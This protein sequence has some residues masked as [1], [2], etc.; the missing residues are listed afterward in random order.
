M[1]TLPYHLI[2]YESSIIGAQFGGIGFSD[3]SPKLLVIATPAGQD[4][5]GFSGPRTNATFSCAPLIYKF[6]CFAKKMYYASSV[7]PPF[8]VLA[9]IMKVF[10]TTWLPDEVLYGEI[11]SQKG[12]NGVLYVTGYGGT[13]A[14]MGK[15]SN[16]MH[17]FIS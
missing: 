5:V 17:E 1:H 11:P 9:S 8:P 12:I 15:F 7:P 4:N 16:N 14:N 3:F 2:V 10:A 13:E 6:M